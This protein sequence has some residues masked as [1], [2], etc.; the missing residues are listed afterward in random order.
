MLY[1]DERSIGT[2]RLQ[3]GIIIKSTDDVVPYFKTEPGLP[4]LHLEG[5]RLVLTCLAEGSWPLEFKWM[6]D[7]SELTTYTSEYKY[8]KFHGYRS[9]K[10]GLSRTCS[11]TQLTA[12]HQLPQ[13]S[14]DLV[15]RRAQ[16]YSKQQNLSPERSKAIAAVSS[17]RFHLSVERPYFS[18]A[19]VLPGSTRVL[20]PENRGADVDT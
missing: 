14:S 4:Q 7:D 20:G 12:H 15:Q 18:T 17:L 2:S 1:A 5:N 19:V 3:E 16:D 13:T 10:N 9:E 6:H 11:C 8:G